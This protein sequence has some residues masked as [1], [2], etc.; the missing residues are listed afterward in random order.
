MHRENNTT[1]TQ[2]STF[3]DQMLDLKEIQVITK[4]GKYIYKHTA[5][6]PC[7]VYPKTKTETRLVIIEYEVPSKQGVDVDQARIITIV[8][9]KAV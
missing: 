1:H 7:S 8:V 4:I 2:V 3:K 9:L 5:P 6:G